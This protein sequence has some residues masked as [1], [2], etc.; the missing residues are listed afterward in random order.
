MDMERF[1]RKKKAYRRDWLQGFETAEAE[2]PD[3][4]AMLLPSKAKIQ[5]KTQQYVEKCT[6]LERLFQKK[7]KL[8]M[9]DLSFLVF[10]ASLQTIRWALINNASGRFD[11]AKQGEKFVEGVGEYLPASIEQLMMDHQVP[12]DA[13]KRSDR[14]IEIYDNESTGLSGVNHRVRALGHDPL[15]GLIFGTA[16][17]ATNTLTVNDWSQLFPS[18]HVRNGEINAKT[19]VY[20]IMK[21][22]GQLLTEKPEVI[23]ASFIK[24][25]VHCGTDLF[26][27]QG[28]PVPVI[29]TV[30][31]EASRFLVGNQIDVYSVVRGAM[32]AILINKIIAMSH[33]L[34]FKYGRDDPKLYEVRT[35]KILLY[36]NTLSSVL[37]LCY[38][39][40]TRDVKRI[41]IGGLA[42]TLYRLLNDREKIN[43]IRLQFIQ[44]TLNGELT[45]KEDEV[46][47]RLAKLGVYI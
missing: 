15:A 24:Q 31:P 1:H 32:L 33:R 29:N 17:I 35:R 14:F 20:H 4:A 19:D 42:V 39:G 7:T 3:Y 21:W 23:G 13:V 38:V 16:N 8:T 22:S 5:H 47:E 18:Y 43:E 41:D 12:Y 11:T 34:F 37:N 27:T 46:K 26:T 36:S 2:K 9:L 25:I 6:E 28:L 30:S 10:A 40:L 45:A 44:E